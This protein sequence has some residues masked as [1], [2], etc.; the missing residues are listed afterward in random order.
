MNLIIDKLQ[1]LEKLNPMYDTLLALYP[2]LV[3]LLTLM[4]DPTSS[5]SRSRFTEIL[6]KLVGDELE[7]LSD[8]SMSNHTMD[9]EELQRTIL[10]F[11]KLTEIGEYLQLPSK[12]PASQAV[13]VGWTRTALF[14]AIQKF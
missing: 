5:K 8:F 11:R 10:H 2:A 1:F 13:F 7:T 6:G 9:Q 12:K 3:R 4:F 14:D